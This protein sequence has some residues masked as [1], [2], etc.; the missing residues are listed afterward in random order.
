VSSVRAWRASWPRGRIPVAISENDSSRVLVRCRRVAADGGVWC[1]HLTTASRRRV[2]ARQ[3]G[4]APRPQANLSNPN[5]PAGITDRLHRATTLDEYDQ[6]IKKEQAAPN[7]L[8]DAKSVIT[9]EINRRWIEDTVAICAGAKSRLRNQQPPG[10]R[11]TDIALESNDREYC[12]RKAVTS[13]DR[14]LPDKAS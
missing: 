11:I 13:P 8:I 7:S 3:R 6:H 5:S 4:K 10:V 2:G 1:C 14:F 9:M 12:K